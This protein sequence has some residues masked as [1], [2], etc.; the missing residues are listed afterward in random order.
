MREWRHA[1]LAV[2]NRGSD[3][4]GC[5]PSR[6]ADQGRAIRRAGPIG[7]V[8]DL[9]VALEHRE[10]RTRR[11]ACASAAA[12]SARRG[13]LGRQQPD[14]RRDVVADDVNRAVVRIRGGAAEVRSSVVARHVDR[15]GESNRR[16]ETFVPGR[17]NPLLE[18]L[19]LGRRDQVRID[20]VRGELLPGER[21]RARGERLRRPD[22][23][24]GHFGLG[25]HGPLLD[26]P[27]RLA[28]HAIEHIE[29]AGFSRH[30]PRRRSTFR[31]CLMVVSCGADVLS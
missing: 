4:L 9:A 13:F 11:R 5:E 1:S 29:E 12:P 2:G 15:V 25:R 7:S 16:E 30:A 8:A 3:L 27:D 22:L 6:D 14:D 31:S 26:R 21:R 10:S 17:C 18:L 19:L 28:R 20:I 23:F 24:A